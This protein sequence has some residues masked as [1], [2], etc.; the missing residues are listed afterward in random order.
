MMSLPVERPTLYVDS[1]V[2]FF[3]GAKNIEESLCQSSARALYL[4]DCQLSADERLFHSIAERGDAVNTGIIFFRA[5][6]DWSVAVER[7]RELQGS[8]TFFTNQTLTHLVMH[9][10]NAAPL[11]PRKF[12]LQLD[13]QFIY[14]DLHARPEIIAR[15]YVNP[16]RHKF[17]TALL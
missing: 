11:D 17:W 3:A 5:P 10:N 9:A 16:V 14:R 15:H 4:S 6:L 8:P 7:L 12:V 2:L 1:D 13:D